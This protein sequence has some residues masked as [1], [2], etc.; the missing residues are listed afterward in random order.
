MTRRAFC[1][2]GQ[3]EK[4]FTE[5]IRNAL[6]WEIE[7]WTEL[8]FYSLFFLYLAVL[9]LS[10]GMQHLHYVMWALPWWHTAGRAVGSVVAAQKL[11]CSEAGE[12]LIPP[13][14]IGH[15]SPALQGRLLTPG[16]P[17]KSLIQHSKKA[18][19]AWR[20]YGICM[21]F[22]T[23]KKVNCN[24][25]RIRLSSGVR[26]FGVEFHEAL[27]HSRREALLLF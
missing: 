16:P 17:G 15:E 22:H 18:F 26:V 19:G 24:G 5:N 4:E 25:G 3:M 7:P 9:G 11:S 1:L 12:I 14:G 20:S 27:S 6:Q 2:E 21:C 10:C 8:V 23:G 13:P